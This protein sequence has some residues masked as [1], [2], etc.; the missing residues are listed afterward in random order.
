LALECNHLCFLTLVFISGGIFFQM[1]W[2]KDSVQ[3]VKKSIIF[4]II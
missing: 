4:I 3:L 2:K 1:M